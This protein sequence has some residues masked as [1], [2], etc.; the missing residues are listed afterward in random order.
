MAGEIMKE[1]AKQANNQKAG[2]PELDQAGKD[3]KSGDPKQEQAGTERL[4]DIAKQ[5][6]D[7]N[8]RKQAEEMLKQAGKPSERPAR[9]PR[10]KTCRRRSDLKP[11]T[12][13]SSSRP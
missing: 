10:R 5:A 6:Q 9:T 7:P 3:L 1:M 2:K 8:I 12:R 13:R 11:P 4:Q